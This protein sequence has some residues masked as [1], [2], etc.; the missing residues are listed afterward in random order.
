MDSRD[1]DG[2]GLTICPG[3]GRHYKPVLGE[4]DPDIIIQKQFPNSTSEE[5]EQ[6]VSGICSDACW[7]K[8]LRGT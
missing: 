3:C 5:R 6:L 1:I 7:D 8:L 4:R 2:E